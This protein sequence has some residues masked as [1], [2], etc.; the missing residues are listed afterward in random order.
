M[1]VEIS[2]PWASL[3]TTASHTI[4]V[5][6]LVELFAALPAT[7]SAQDYRH[8]VVEQNFLGR[9]TVNGRVRTFRHL[10]ELYILDPNEPLFQ[11]LRICWSDNPA[12]G[13]VL[14]AL[15]AFSRDEI[16]RAS[17]PAIR[18]ATPGDR[19]SS[20]DLTRAASEKF[21]DTL[22]ASTLGKIGR[23]TGA[24]WTQSGHLVGRAQKVRRSVD[25][26]GAAVAFA[27][28]LGYVAGERGAYLLRTPWFD[29][30]DVPDQDRLEAVRVAHSRGL[31]TVR[32]TGGM[33]EISPDRLVG[34][35][36]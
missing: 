9:P 25:A 1:P 31:I 18:D 20:H 29:L 28:L 2:P 19:V 12:A 5:P 35:I 6:H 24:S 7:S 32:S 4:G 14:A 10:R 17:W 30:L 34:H 27:V 15:L 13:P 26:S 33:L 3:R 23:N 11:A 36:K 8:V 16:L 22:S 21:G